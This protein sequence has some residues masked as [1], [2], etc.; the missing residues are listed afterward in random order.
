MGDSKFIIELGLS[1]SQS[2]G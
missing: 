2:L 1:C